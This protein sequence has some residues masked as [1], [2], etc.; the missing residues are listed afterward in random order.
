MERR[1]GTFRGVAADRV[2]PPEARPPVLQGALPVDPKGE[3]PLPEA[4][5]SL[6]GTGYGEYPERPA[7]RGM[8]G[9]SP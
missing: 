9:P 2:L 8:G 6:A 4:T 1:G 7:V 3:D 5:I